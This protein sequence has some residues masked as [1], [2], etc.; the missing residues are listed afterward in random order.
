MMYMRVGSP[1]YAYALAMKAVR[2]RRISA[3]VRLLETAERSGSD[4]DACAGAKWSC[5][6]LLGRFEDAWSESERIASR[7]GP[8]LWKGECFLGKRVIVRCLHGFGDAI[9]FVRY[10]QLLGRVASRVIVQTHPEL[11]SLMRTSNS[12]DEA[13][14]WQDEN[15][16]TWDVEIEV[17]ELPRA[18]GATLATVPSRT[19]YFHIPANVRQ[20][21]C[22][23]HRRV[24]APGIGLQWGSGAWDPARSIPLRELRSLAGLPGC[25]YLSFQRGAPREEIG[26]V[27]E[28]CLT[29]VSGESPHVIEAAA[30]LL[31]VDLLITVD[32]MLAHLAGALG[33]PVWVL[34]P[35]Q[36]D[37]RWMLDR[38]DS[39]WY[40][41]M[42]LFRQPKPGDWSAPVSAMVKELKGW[43]ANV[44]CAD[45]QTSIN[46]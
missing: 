42:R 8:G 14:S 11:V 20:N 16:K 22:V 19:P 18:F 31:N 21:S 13:I 32:T 17:M 7:H 40:P 45:A 30:D 29:D 24:G 46:S 44:T 5:Y 26:G 43:I 34:L 33:L 23:P 2:E 28:L 15:P 6:M 37:W 1:G 4:F 25:E 27:P 3:A 36:A 39:P 9:Q 38:A 41:T 10:A 12:V 35:Y